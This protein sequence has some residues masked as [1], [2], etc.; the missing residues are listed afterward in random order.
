[1]DNHDLNTEIEMEV[2][3]SGDYGDK[4][5]YTAATLDQIAGDY[6]PD[7]LEAP[8]TFDHAQAGPAYG[9][10]TRLARQ[11]DRLVAAIKGVPPAVRDLIRSGAYKRRSVELFRLM[12]QTGRPYLRAVSLLGAATP[13]VKGLRDICFHA[14]PIDIA[15]ETIPLPDESS[16]PISDPAQLHHELLSSRVALMFAELRADG[17]CLPARDAEAIRHIFQQHEAT[18]S[19]SDGSA[20]S[21]LEWMAGFLRQHLVRAPLGEAAPGVASLASP[22]LGVKG[23]AAF[24][25]RV[26]PRSARLH[27]AAQEMQGATP[28]LTYRDALLRAAAL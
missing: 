18:V 12:P 6:R 15:T 21:T 2:F 14:A 26:E 25:D 4:G 23:S 1:M 24:S 11:G 22:P 7:L 3:R 28:G 13:E 16:P 10:V 20:Q 19:F 8:L 5:A 27:R 9:W 17:Y